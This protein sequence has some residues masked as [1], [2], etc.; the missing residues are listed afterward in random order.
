MPGCL[1]DTVGNTKG[2]M[3]V[4]MQRALVPC[5]HTSTGCAAAGEFFPSREIGIKLSW[6]WSSTVQWQSLGERQLSEKLAAAPLMALGPQWGRDEGSKFAVPRVDLCPLVP[7]LEHED[8]EVSH[9]HLVFNDIMY[10]VY[11]GPPNKPTNLSS[12]QIKK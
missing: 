9:L 8:L 3:K 10:F 12:S 2:E 7:F 5:S 6:V 1:L 11:P 4:L